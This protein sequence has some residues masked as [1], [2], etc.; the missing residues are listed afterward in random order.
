MDATA[1]WNSNYILAFENDYGASA[2]LYAPKSIHAWY[3]WRPLLGPT[4]KGGFAVLYWALV[5]LVIAL[6][7]GVFGF[8]GIA[9][10][11]SGI[12]QILFTLFLILFLVSLIMHVVRGRSPP[13]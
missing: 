10:S 2:R 9:A 8:G 5:F 12:A 11:A 4:R 3:R 1:Q 13:L 6:I 7:A